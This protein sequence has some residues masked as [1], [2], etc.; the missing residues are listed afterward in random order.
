[1]TTASAVVS[2]NSATYSARAEIFAMA[3]PTAPQQLH[4]AVMHAEPAQAA[5]TPPVANIL[6]GLE[7]R[8]RGRARRAAVAGAVCRGETRRE[9][10]RRT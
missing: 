7:E 1:M 8:S 6:E 9:V 5:I 3:P 2:T 10:S 4:V